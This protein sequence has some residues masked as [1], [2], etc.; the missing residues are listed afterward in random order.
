MARKTWT[1]YIKDSSGAW[2]LDTS[3]PRPNDVFRLP[4]TSTQVKVK[5]ANG[6]NAFITPEVKSEKRTLSFTWL[7]DDGTIKT[8]IETY[9]NN[10]EDIKII[11]HNN[12]IYIGRFISIE[13]NWVLGVEPDEYDITAILEQMPNL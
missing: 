4:L 1:T 11:D 5:L 9:I 7:A 3:L 6:D 8:Q 13:S 10:Q 2:V 12:N